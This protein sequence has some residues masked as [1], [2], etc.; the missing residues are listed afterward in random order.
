[1]VLNQM[2]MRLH[3]CLMT[4]LAI[5]FL[6]PITGG[7]L[8]DPNELK[9]WSGRELELLG[10]SRKQDPY[11]I[12]LKSPD[13]KHRE[14]PLDQET[15]NHLIQALIPIQA[16]KEVVSIRGMEYLF[17]FQGGRNPVR[18]QIRTTGDH[19]EYFH[20]NFLYQGGNPQAFQKV[21]DDLLKKSPE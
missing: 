8:S 2:K 20:G 9:P 16:T 4:L 18:I 6:V 19:L 10:F 3:R 21:I 11:L 14:I 15:A 7:C 12:L 17:G 1:M 5:A 13:G